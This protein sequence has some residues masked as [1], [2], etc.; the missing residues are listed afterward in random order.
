[1]SAA[2]K[3]REEATRVLA[4]ARR[5]GIFGLGSPCESAL[6]VLSFGGGQDSWTILHKLCTDPAYR[7]RYVV[8]R[9]IVVMSDTGNEHPETY[10]MLEKARA[11]CEAANVEFYF[12]TAGDRFHSKSW[13]SLVEFYNRTHTVGSKAYPKTCTDHLKLRPIYRFLEEYV[14]G[15][16]A[17]KRG[18]IQFA[19]KRG[20]VRVILGIAAGE[21]S[22]VADPAKDAPWM[23]QS[24]ERVYPLIKEGW[25]RKE[26]IQYLAS[27]GLRVTPSNCMFCPFMSEVELL[28]LDRFYPARLQEWVD[29]EARKLQANQHA[30]EKNFG[31]WG[32]R[33]LP[34]VLA[35]AKA[36]HPGITDAELWDYKMSHGHCTKTKY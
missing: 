5:L 1:M 22:R 4:G 31:V 34:Q 3:F 14:S 16:Q 30:G 19:Q 32:R 29:I 9:L 33:T 25:A 8:G 10:Q 11:L 15:A 2:I 24:V 17:R 27:H 36:K 28:W 12:L 6:T 21:E 7:A 26:C 23:R 20:K 35:E 18:M 13:P